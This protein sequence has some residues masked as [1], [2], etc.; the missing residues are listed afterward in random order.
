MKQKK[1]GNGASTVAGT[2]CDPSANGRQGPGCA[3]D[4]KKP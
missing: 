3:E 4:S 2:G 1:H